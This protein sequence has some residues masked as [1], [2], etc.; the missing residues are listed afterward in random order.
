MSKRIL[1]ADDSSFWR[2]RFR[3]LL[4]RDPDL[5]VFEAG[6]GSEAV[7]NSLKFR[8]DLVVLD[9]SMPVLDGLGAARELHRMMPKLP[10]L[11]CTVDK[12][13]CL[14]DVARETG[15]RAVFSKLEW[16]EMLQFIKL[17]LSCEHGGTERYQPTV[18]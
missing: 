4:E 7:Q 3:A 12:S 9:Y 16:T 2:E 1:I 17:K 5:D 15:V 10:V 13:A 8:P 11:L 6:N 18:A 14:E